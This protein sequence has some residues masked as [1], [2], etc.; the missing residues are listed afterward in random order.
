[1]LFFLRTKKDKHINLRKKSVKNKICIFAVIV[2]MLSLSMPSMYGMEYF[3]KMSR[4]VKN[5]YESYTGHSRPEYAWSVE[6]MNDLRDDYDYRQ[7]GTYFYY[8]IS[9]N[10]MRECLDLIKDYAEGGDII[11]C[12]HFVRYI[13]KNKGTTES[14]R[15]CF[16]YV[17]ITY[18]LAKAD[19]LLCNTLFKSIRDEKVIK[20]ANTFKHLMDKYYYFLTGDGPEQNIIAK[21]DK[22]FNR[23][24]TPKDI[25]EKEV[26]PWFE[27]FYPDINEVKMGPSLNNNNDRELLYQPLEKTSGISFE[28]PS[29]E[30]EKVIETFLLPLPCWVRSVT[31]SKG[32]I[33]CGNTVVFEKLEESDIKA[34]KYVPHQKWITIFRPQEIRKQINELRT[35]NSWSEVFENQEADNN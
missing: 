4:T 24:I 23:G 34:C 20:G 27:H 10:F 11:G 30:E 2:T 13:G 35:K 33:G 18:I 5:I 31:L 16:K 22:N 25:L 21:E 26:I 28:M 32:L 29:E 1:M 15:L 7:L 19:Y 3:S 9:D 12:Y 8:Y 17:M 14:I 6:K